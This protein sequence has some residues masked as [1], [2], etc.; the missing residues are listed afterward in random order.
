MKRRQV[1]KGSFLGVAGA[2]VSSFVSGRADALASVAREFP[3]D[4]DASREL[5]RVDW[6][7]VFL[8]DHQNQTLI[9]LSD[10]II[11]ETESPGAKQA[12]ANRFIDLLLAAETPE[13]QRSFLNSLAFLDGLSIKRQGS[14]FVHLSKNDQVAMLNLIAYPHTLGTWGEKASEF[15]GHSHFENLKAWIVRAYYSSEIGMRELGWD[16]SPIH[17]DLQGCTHS[18]SEHR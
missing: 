16:G 11:P 6:K 8:D 2:A 5:S 7:P 10:L 13:V 1:L 17:G 3:V 18:P 12:L 14:G 15:E 9:V 4:A